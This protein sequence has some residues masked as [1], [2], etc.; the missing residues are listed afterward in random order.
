M[1][2]YYDRYSGFRGN[3]NMKPIPGINI[4]DTTSD[5]TMMYKQ[6]ISRL[7]KLS[8][9][10]YNNPYSGWLIMLANP[11]YGGLEFNIPDMTI[12]KIP[13]PFESAI[14]RYTTQVRIHKSLYGE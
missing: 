5:K 7:D 13:Y 12:I 11:Q 3:S 2:T 1:A 14:S 4:P 8:Q 10:Y 6:G 9:T